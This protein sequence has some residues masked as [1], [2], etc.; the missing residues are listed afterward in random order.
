MVGERWIIKSLHDLNIKESIPETGSTIEENAIIKAEF[1]F[2]NHQVACF[3]DDSGLE[4]F[5]LNGEP[6][7]FSA[8]YAGD[9]KDDM[10]N[11]AKLLANLEGKTNRAAQFKTVICHIDARGEKRVFI[12]TISGEISHQMAGNNGFGYDP[13]FVPDGYEITF[14]EMTSEEKNTISHRARAMQQLKSFLINTPK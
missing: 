3:A 7:V 9:K 12:G 5:A 10:A 13:L 4:V 11:M 6:G 8:R 2:E 14:A 1:L